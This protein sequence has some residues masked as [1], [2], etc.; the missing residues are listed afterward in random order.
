MKKEGNE[1]KHILEIRNVSKAF[2]GVKALDKIFFNLKKGEVHALVGENGAGK[3][4]LLKI[5]AG[6]YKKDEG[7]IIL[8]GEEVEIIGPKHALDMGISVIYQEF[9]LIPNLSIAENI[10]LGREPRAR[11]AFVNFPKLYKEA[12]FFLRKIGMRESPKTLVKNLSVAQQQ[13]VEIA[14]ALSFSSRII[15]MDEPTSALT[16][17][18]KNT[19]FKIIREL[20]DKDVSVIFVSHIINEV[21]EIADRVTVLRDGKHIGTLDIQKTT[22]EEIVRMMVGRKLKDFYP[23]VEAKK[24]K[25]ILEVKNL[26]KKPK[27]ENISF[28][29]H[30]G[31]VL[32]FAGLVGSGREEVMRGIFGIEAPHSGEIYIKG[33]RLER[34]SHFERI[35]LK[36]GFVPEDRRNEGLILIASLKD[37]INITKLPEINF[38][39]IV[40]QK[41]EEKIANEYCKRLKIKALDTKQI[42][43]NLSGGNQQKVV[44]AKWLV[45]DPG[46]LI[47]DDPTRGIDVG[48]KNE[49]YSLINELAKKGIGIILISS[50]LP[51]IINMSDRI[52]VMR[53][54]KIIG[55]FLKKEATQEKIMKLAALRN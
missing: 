9:N 8:D 40:R 18:E 33:K 34:N 14:K 30:E 41:E 21:F 26:T 25:V 38:Y 17:S 24:G 47:L 39:G 10:F 43:Q 51:E 2:P 42:V 50:E 22:P 23:K 6:A 45:I 28:K 29:L 49:I 35:R 31:E 12:E 53:E 4:T 27:Y 1:N 15:I 19:L 52:L 13:M 48:A 44:I 11:R 37:N 36:M 16:E 20:K 46:I 55:E 54:G 32:G 7:K 3:S 5:L